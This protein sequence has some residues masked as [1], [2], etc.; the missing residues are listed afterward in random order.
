MESKFKQDSLS[1]FGAKGHNHGPRSELGPP[2]STRLAELSK[3]SRAAVEHTPGNL[4]V[5]GS[6]PARCWLFF[7]FFFFFLFFLSLPTFLHQCSVLNQ[8]PQKEEHL[9][10]SFVKEIEKN[11]CLAELPGVKKAQ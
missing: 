11:G 3:K 9:Y 7:S 5:V 1:P 4:V 8:V 6:N 10:L 2:N